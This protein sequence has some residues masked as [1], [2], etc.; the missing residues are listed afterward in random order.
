MKIIA[1]THPSSFDT[2]ELTIAC[3]KTCMNK[4]DHECNL[5]KTKYKHQ[6]W[7]N[8]DAIVRVS[9]FT[10]R[11]NKLSIST[12]HTLIQRVT[13]KFVPFYTLVKIINEYWKPKLVVGKPFGNW[14]NARLPMTYTFFAVLDAATR[15][16]PYRIFSRLDTNISQC[17]G[18][19]E[20]KN[21]WRIWHNVNRDRRN[22][23]WRIDRL[24]TRPQRLLFRLCWSALSDM[25]L[26]SWW[27]L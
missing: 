7:Y 25:S 17:S 26:G 21:R 12:T 24:P 9:W 3:Y 8:R 2:L 15:R 13:S 19:F 18:V 20:S 27:C 23:N 6:R 10:H 11:Y 1:K 14:C 22:R 16:L 5:L 4:N